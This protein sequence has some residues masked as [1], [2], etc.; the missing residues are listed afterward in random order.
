MESGSYKKA[1]VDI[2]AGKELAR[3]LARMAKPTQGPETLSGIGGFAALSSLPAGMEDPVLVSSTD[4]VGTKLRIAFATGVHNTVGIDLVAMGVNDI[5]TV[6]ARPLFFLDYLATGKLEVDEAEAV[7]TGIIDGCRRA[8]CAL[9]GGETAEL[10]GMY[11]PGEYDLAGFAVGVVERERVIDG[12]KVEAGDLVVGLPSSGLHSNGYSLARAALLEGPDALDLEQEVEDLGR[13]VGQELLEPTRIYT[14]ALFRLLEHTEV[15]GVA[16]ITGGGLVENAPR[17]VP[18]SL[19]FRFR[20]GSWAVPP[21]MELIAR[22]G[23]VPPEE[24]WRTFNM[25]LGMLIVLPERQATAAVE[26]LSDEQARIVA[27]I[28]PRTMGRAVEFNL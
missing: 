25:G 8:G 9:L 21:V 18:G 2:D 3:R 19:A 13:T 6:G 27:E 7:V 20:N 14:S 22:K 26:I 12:S 17:C 16:H 23:K 5:L 4:G 28:V 10:P 11:N 1:G 15:R 24:M